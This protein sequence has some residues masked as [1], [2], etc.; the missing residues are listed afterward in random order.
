[1]PNLHYLRR[2]IRTSFHVHAQASCRLC[3]HLFAITVP[4]TFF[5]IQSLERSQLTFQSMRGFWEMS[6]SSNA[7]ELK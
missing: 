2:P 4:A 7:R 6:I 3:N 5:A 1:M